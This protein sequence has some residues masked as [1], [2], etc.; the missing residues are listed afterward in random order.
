MGHARALLG[1]EDVATQL[2]VYQ[3][4]LVEGLSVRDVE[5]IV[6][7]LSVNAT[8]KSEDISK[9]PLRQKPQ[10]FEQA[11]KDLDYLYD[12]KVQLKTKVNG[13]GSI[14]LQFE[15]KDELGRIL[16]LLKK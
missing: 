7:N 3:D 16:N 11:Q 13:K 8:N 2:E 15:S 12:C 4:I 6:K 14:I 5:D 9:P 1:I 10:E